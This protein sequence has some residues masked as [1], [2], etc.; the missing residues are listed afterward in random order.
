M[1]D[2]TLKR[3][4]ANL[5]RLAQTSDF[6]ALAQFVSDRSPAVRRRALETLTQY[7]FDGLPQ[8][9][10][11]G[12]ADDDERVRVL[13]RETLIRHADAAVPVLANGLRDPRR[14][15]LCAA[16]LASSAAGRRVLESVPGVV[17]HLL[18]VLLDAEQ[19]GLLRGQCLAFVERL[20]GSTIDIAL[21]RCLSDRELQVREAALA[22][23]LRRDTPEG[24]D[25][26]LDWAESNWREA[27][28]L[29]GWLAVHPDPRSRLVLERMAGWHGLL[30]MPLRRCQEAR[31]A[32]GRL[33]RRHA[34]ASDAALSRAKAPAP[35]RAEAALSKAASPDDKEQRRTRR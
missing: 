32:L 22:A 15:A 23:L 12:L 28:L 35:A 30:A 21:G 34:V 16:L 17:E 13:C 25:A 29:I 11:R 6:Q 2:Q 18:D 27:G 31:A 24:N 3:R 7:H 9:L 20:R 5:R 4:L 1:D 14:A 26:L 19:P 8:L 10:V 33:R